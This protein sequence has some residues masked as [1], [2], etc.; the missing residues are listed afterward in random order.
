LNVFPIRI[1]PLR[2]RLVDIPVLAQYLIERYATQAGKSIRTIRR[3]T[4]ELLQA[5]DWPGNVRELQ[6]VIERA[7]IL[8]EARR[9][10]STSRGSRGN[11]A[12]AP[13][14]WRAT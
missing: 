12:S 5:Y 11:R 9:L 7:V 14:T 4:L 6:N 8:C 13:R 3:Q 1:P 2:E 10:P